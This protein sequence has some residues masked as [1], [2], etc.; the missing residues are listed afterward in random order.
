MGSYRRATAPRPGHAGPDP[1]LSGALAQG[2]RSANRKKATLRLAGL[3]G[4]V[5]DRRSDFTHRISTTIA[6]THG[7]ICIEDLA[8]KNM[9]KNRYLARSV[10]D[11][12]WGELGYQL[13]YKAN[14]YG[15][16]W[17]YPRGTSPRPRPA[18]R[19]DGSFKR[20]PFRTGSFAARA[21][22]SSLTAT[23][24][25]L[26]TS[27]PGA[28]PSTARP[29]RPRTPKHGAGSPMPVEGAALAVTSVTVEL[30]SRPRIPERSRNRSPHQRPKPDTREGWSADG[31]SADAVGTAGTSVL[32]QRFL[33]K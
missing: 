7:A 16:I 4:R 31:L 22:A 26:P 2:A 28:R 3:H 10:M 30:L 14:W 20:S 23:P 15:E 11:A 33:S 25:P 17:W 18:R 6:K 9:V 27:P 32:T 13:R 12:A 21:A 8:V 24:M 5:A 29:P 1:S 19:A